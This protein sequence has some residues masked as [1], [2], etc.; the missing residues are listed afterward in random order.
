[1]LILYLGWAVSTSTPFTIQ[2][3]QALAEPKGVLPVSAD[4]RLHP[5]SHV[6]DHAVD[7]VVKVRVFYSAHDLPQL[8]ESN[9]SAIGEPVHQTLCRDVVDLMRH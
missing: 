8:E 6:V 7:C 9:V 3:V 4:V 2:S 1:M 5:V